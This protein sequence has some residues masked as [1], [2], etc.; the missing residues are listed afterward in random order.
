MNYDLYNIVI[1]SN[2]Y[3]GVALQEELPR[4]ALTK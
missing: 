1:F 3:K 4:K 2:R